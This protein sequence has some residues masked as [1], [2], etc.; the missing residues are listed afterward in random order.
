MKHSSELCE[1]WIDILL[2]VD[3]KNGHEVL[4]VYN[5]IDDFVMSNIDEFNKRKVINAENA[6]VEVKD[7][8]RTV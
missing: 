5:P 8:C 2:N 4:F 3:R 1:T 6:Q 7:V